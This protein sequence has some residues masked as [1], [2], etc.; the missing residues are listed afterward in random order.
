MKKL[1]VTSSPHVKSGDTV[2]GIMLDVIIAL[3]PALIAAIQIFGPR[4]LLVTAV[5]V[6]ACVLTEYISRKIMKRNSTIGDL[7]AVV[8]GILLAFNLP[9]TI[10]LWMV[11]I[12]AV[13]AI[14]VVKQMFG[15]LGQNFVNPAITGRIVML[16]SFGAA[17]TSF[18]KPLEWTGHPD[19]I[20]SATPLALLSEIDRSGD[21]AA[22]LANSSLPSLSDMFFGFIGG[23]LGEVCTAALLIGG[24]YLVIRKVISPIIPI[25]FIGTTAVI[26][27]IASKGSLT[28]TAYELFGGGL[29]LGAIFMATDYATSPVN[30]LGKV[31]FGI[32]C[33][34]IASVIRLYSNLPEGVSYAIMIMNILVPLIEKVSMPK[35]FGY[36]KEKKNKK[37][38][39]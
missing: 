2:T 16:V 9:S 1:T 6:A 26:M 7:S 30:R 22:Q 23:S 19:A 35:P 17:M 37:E 8:T 10:P 18:P 29:M 33:G 4:A 13:A 32:G 11:V 14:A 39:V 34:I 12:G 31:I 3:V 28:F 5:S 36:V 25:S 21:I 24:A 38:A 15:G 27:L 20:T